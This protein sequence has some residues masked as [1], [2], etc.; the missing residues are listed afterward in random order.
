MADP[1]YDPD[2]GFLTNQYEIVDS[3][4][5]EEISQLEDVVFLESAAKVTD[6]VGYV[7]GTLGFVLGGLASVGIVSDSWGAGVRCHI[8]LDVRAV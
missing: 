4:T 7:A 2:T 1:K 8:K 3:L 5:S 6:T